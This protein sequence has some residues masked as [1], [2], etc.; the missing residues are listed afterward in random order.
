MSKGKKI[1]EASEQ[2]VPAE[3]TPGLP[4]HADGMSLKDKLSVTVSLFKDVGWVMILT[5]GILIVAYYTLFPSRGFF[6]SDTTDTIMW[7]AASSENGK[8]FNPD[9]QYACILPFGTS[10]IMWALIPIFGITM[11]THVLGMLCFF[12]LYTGSLIWMLRKMGWSWW[13]VS[14]TVFIELM[15]CS[16]S[17]KLR[18]IFWGHTIYYSLGILFIFVG[19]SLI[20]SRMDLFGKYDT[21]VAE[22]GQKKTKK[23]IIIFTVLIGIWF[24]LTCTDQIIA[25]T[26][27]ALPVM[28]A[29]FCE[30]WLDTAEKP[31]CRKNRRMLIGF[32]VMGVGMVLGYLLTKVLTKD[33]YASYETTFSQYTNM[34]A[35][36][37]N[38]LKFPNAWITLLGVEAVDGDPLM[39]VKSIGNLLMI[40]TG[41]IL[42]AVPAIALIFYRKI[43]DEKLRILI[44]TFWFMTLLILMGYTIGRLSDANWRLSPIVALS[45]VVTAAFVKW[46]VKQISFQRIMPLLMVP[47]VLVS[48]ITAVTIMKMPSDNTEDIELYVLAEELEARGL[49]YGYATFWYANALTIISDSKVTC[50]CIGGVDNNGPW[51][52]KYQQCG[53][54]FDDQPGQEKYFI[55]L[56]QGD[57]E[58]MVENQHPLL[59]SLI[60]EFTVN[61]QHI[62]VFSRNVPWA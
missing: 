7:A 35:W 12:L 30:R 1:P 51:R 53:S 43:D 33:I 36:T 5:L 13:W 15:I 45:A 48:S 41:V 49:D 10:L 57:I 26:I 21:M 44:L 8:L 19:L 25:I 16:G 46:S 39:S 18:E 27:F 60:D 61:E 17:V 62:L 24:L 47:V 32:I 38:F 23:Q 6:H 56:S 28:A 29:V 14:G 37:N 20:F 58:K 4:A 59:E 42:L 9:F 31:F 34:D 50:R 2:A 52:N 22:A 3:K 40:L 55:I 54:W 11:T